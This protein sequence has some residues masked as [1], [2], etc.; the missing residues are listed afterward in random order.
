MEI[1]VWP[2]GAGVEPSAAL[3]DDGLEIGEGGE[4]PID[5]G[6]VD[7]RPEMLG[8]LQFRTV[9]RQEDEADPLGDD[10]ALRPVPA[11]IVEHQDDVALPARAG[12][13]CE[14][15]EQRLEEGLRQAGREIPDWISRMA[16]I[17]LARS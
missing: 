16:G 1:R 12:P 4:V 7:L 2:D 6:L 11:G 15:G 17:L 10:Q 5:D 9:G 14:A 8:R 13:A 3:G